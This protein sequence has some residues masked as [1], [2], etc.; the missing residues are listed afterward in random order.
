MSHVYV[1]RWAITLP[2]Y[3]YDTSIGIDICYEIVKYWVDRFGA[4]FAEE[5]R[6]KIVCNHS[7]RQWHLDEVSS[8]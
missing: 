6:K 4:K 5:I 3:V 1:T 8:K 7:N 2:N